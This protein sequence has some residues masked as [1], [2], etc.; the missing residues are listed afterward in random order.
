M[1]AIAEG[2]FGTGKIEL[3]HPTETFVIKPG[4]L[5]A[6]LA[7][8]SLPTFQRFRVV[9]TQHFHIR[10]DQSAALDRSKNLAER[11]RVAAREY[12]LRDPGIGCSR[13]VASANRVQQHDTVVAE[14]FT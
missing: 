6:V 10:H 9:Q 3:P 14:Q 5:R 8:A 2:H 1:S 7:K 4:N 13:P 11:R 12:I